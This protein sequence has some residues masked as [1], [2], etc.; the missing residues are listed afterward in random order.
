MG[1]LQRARVVECAATQGLPAAVVMSHGPSETTLAMANRYIN[2]A[3]ADEY[4]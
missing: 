1:S 3:M 4:W 2:I